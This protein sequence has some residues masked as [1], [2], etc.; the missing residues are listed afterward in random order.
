MEK[1]LK[2]SQ[3]EIPIKQCTKL[4]RN[5]HRT[6]QETHT[7]NTEKI[8]VL[9]TTRVRIDK[10]EFLVFPCGVLKGSEPLRLYVE[11]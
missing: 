3:H 4:Q 11:L 5:K 6:M 7:I 8:N 9:K 2:K 10:R 1:F